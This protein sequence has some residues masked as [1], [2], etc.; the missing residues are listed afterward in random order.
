MQPTAIQ[1]RPENPPTI[2]VSA[3]TPELLPATARSELTTCLRRRF[4][5]DEITPILDA[6]EFAAAAHVGQKRKNGEPYITH[7]VKVAEIVSEWQLDRNA[8]IAALLHDVVEDTPVTVP[9]IA[10]QFGD[11]IA[12]LV[13][14]LSKIEQIEQLDKQH[15][16]QANSQEALAQLKASAS[17]R[18]L[19]LAISRDW[20]VILVKIADRLHNMRTLENINSRSKRRRI[21]QETLD[22]YAPIAERLGFMETCGEL[23]TL[24]FSHIHPVRYSVLSNAMERSRKTMR[25]SIPKI[26]RSITNAMKKTGVEVSIMTREK[27]V[28]SVYRKMIEK[29]L[30]FNEVDD[31][32]GFRLVV[33]KQLDC[34]IT[35]GV[36]HELFRPVPEKLKDY[37]ALP[38]ANGYQSIHTTVLT[39]N[40]AIIE[41]QL[42]TWEMHRYAEHGLAAHSD[43]K[44]LA[45]LTEQD[46]RKAPRKIQDH[47]NRLLSNLMSLSSDGLDSGEFL[48][49]MRLDLF[50]NEVVVLTPKGKVVELSRGATALDM[51]YA[52]HTELGDKAKEAIINGDT[53]TISTV[54]N[55]GDI[56]EI[57]TAANITPN[58]QW[59]NFVATPRARI[60][61]RSQLRHNYSEEMTQLGKSLLEQSLGLHGYRLEELKDGTMDKFLAN[62]YANQTTADLYVEIALGKM[63]PEVIA[64]ELIGPHKH[65]E[66]REQVLSIS[67]A[68]DH[69]SGI[70]RAKCCEPLP[71]EEIIGILRKNFG[72]DVH[73]KNCPEVNSQVADKKYF[74]LNWDTTS[75]DSTYKV[76]LSL[77][78]NNRQGLLADIIAKFPREGVNIVSMNLGGA[79][80]ASPVA[81]I[82][83][84][85]E[86]RDAK[87]IERVFSEINDING[88]SITRA[89][90]AAQ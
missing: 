26:K 66:A 86:V 29:Q 28:Y 27:N 30:S 10:Q 38:K 61:L 13:N 77:S 41:L 51:A 75:K 9:E 25:K 62:N 55:S 42:R 39:K 60:H 70:N 21:A 19:L 64:N 33:D 67:I 74:V 50:P 35:L 32:I 45:L 89:G 46:R 90:T 22:I 43:Y 18:K 12:A 4:R 76:S 34:Y 85:A 6:A 54:L 73:R 68:G 8:I 63:S 78:C 31:I 37:I 72:L 88:V 11:E 40:G 3:G 56:V 47:T 7:P 65:R 36:I 23:Q 49:N 59:L 83:L 53:K 16:E 52:I 20:R 58:P 1:Q 15:V 87:Q 79:S 2:E 48:R 71:P 81:Q 69:H 5:K 84:E 80:E 24:S 82:N 57:I 14:G 17:F 44:E